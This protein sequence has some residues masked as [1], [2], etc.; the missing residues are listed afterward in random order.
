MP[1]IRNIAKSQGR[2][3]EKSKVHIRQRTSPM[4]EP[5]LFLGDLRGKIWQRAA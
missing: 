4:I 1:R 3:Q 5:L 2:T